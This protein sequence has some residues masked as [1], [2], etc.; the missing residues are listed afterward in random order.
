MVSP[1][2]ARI[3]HIMLNGE[4]TAG[5][6]AEGY[7]WATA[8]HLE[9]RSAFEAFVECVQPSHGPRLLVG[10]VAAAVLIASGQLNRKQ[11][12]DRCEIPQGGSRSRVGTLAKQIKDARCSDYLPALPAEWAAPPVLAPAPAADK[13]TPKRKW[14]QLVQ[15]PDLAAELRAAKES[16]RAQEDSA[17]SP[18]RTHRVHVMRQRTPEGGCAIATYAANVTPAEEAKEA[19]G[20]RLGANRERRSQAFKVLDFRL[21]ERAYKG[22]TLPFKTEQRQLLAKISTGRRAWLDKKLAQHGPQLL[23]FNP[24]LLEAL[25]DPNHGHVPWAWQGSVQGRDICLRMEYD[26]S[27]KA[28]ARG[29]W[30]WWAERYVETNGLWRKWYQEWCAEDCPCRA[31]VPLTPP[32]EV[33]PCPECGD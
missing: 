8:R 23:D 4:P 17:L 20:R 12:C 2:L 30:W 13:K 27:A 5:T 25:A 16:G 9:G 26:F 10:A 15:R 18:K 14:Q 28:L 1:L 32:V 3:E 7:P 11:A 24:G 22:G 21:V 33:G 6:C 29:R 31:G 19:R